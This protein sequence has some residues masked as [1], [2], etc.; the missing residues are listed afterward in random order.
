VGIRVFCILASIAFLYP[1]SSAI[2]AA[3]GRCQQQTDGQ[4][5]A[6]ERAADRQTKRDIEVASHGNM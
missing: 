4:Q 3:V 2:A 1:P 5:P 6:I